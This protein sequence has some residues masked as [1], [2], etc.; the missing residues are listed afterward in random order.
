LVR[1]GAMALTRIFGANSAASEKA[2]P[3]TAPFT[4]AKEAWKESPCVTAMVENS[5]IEAEGAAF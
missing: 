1:E 2:S 3:S 5:T 4:A